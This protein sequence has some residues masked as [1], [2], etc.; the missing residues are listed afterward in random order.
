MQGFGKHEYSCSV[1]LLVVFRK[2]R[3]FLWRVDPFLTA[4]NFQGPKTWRLKSDDVLRETAG[5]QARDAKPLGASLAADEILEGGQVCV[6][7]VGAK[8]ETMGCSFF[9]RQ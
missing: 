9:A 2:R 7:D 8:A 3:F 1:S 4:N 5:P 6:A